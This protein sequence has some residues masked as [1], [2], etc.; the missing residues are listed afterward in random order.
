MGSIAASIGAWLLK[1]A[2]G[3]FLGKVLAVLAKTDSGSIRLKELE[4]QVQIA[5]GRSEA[6][7]AKTI[8][9]ARASAQAAKMN[10][11][12][13]WVL[14]V[15]MMGPPLILLWSVGLYNILWWEHGI[16]PQQWSIADFPPSIKPWAQAAVDWLFDPLGPPSGIGSALAAGWLTRR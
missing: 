9:A 10:W 14:I 11:P 7:L 6:E 16:W 5:Q 8:I 1:V 12:V 3:D 2:T 4:T 15:A 13:F